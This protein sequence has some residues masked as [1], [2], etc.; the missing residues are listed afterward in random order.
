MDDCVLGISVPCAEHIIGVAYA[1]VEDMFMVGS[2]L[3]MGLF[4][5]DAYCI[6]CFA[7]WFRGDESC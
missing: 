1:I 2:C 3:L 6:F 4:V 7:G 5:Y